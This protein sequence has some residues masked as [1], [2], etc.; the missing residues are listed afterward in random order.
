MSILK[1]SLILIPVFMLLSACGGGDGCAPSDGRPLD[2]TTD[3]S[4]NCANTRAAHALSI[5]Y[6]NIDAINQLDGGGAGIYSYKGSILV[7]DQNGNAVADD[8]IVQL[9]VFDTLIVRGTIAAGDTISGSIITDNAGIVQGDDTTATTINTAV[10]TRNLDISRGVQVGDLV[11]LINA[12]TSDR[13][14]YVA[15]TTANSITVNTPY[16]N[17]YPSALYPA[18]QYLVGQALIPA[19]VLGTDPDDETLKTRGVSKTR[20]GVAAFRLEYPNNRLGYGNTFS[21]TGD[22]RE[23]PFGS[24]SVW[25]VANVGGS[26]ATASP[27]SFPG[28]APGQILISPGVIPGSQ[29]VTITVLDANNGIMAFT[30]VG[31]GSGPGGSGPGC[32]TDEDGQCDSFVTVSGTAG[33]I[34][35]SIGTATGD[36]TY[37][38]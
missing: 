33:T 25:V 2:T 32:V 18:A 24:A 15:S 31:A 14:R 19:S 21:Y 17:T 5:S 4:A 9:D 35:Y 28:I 38:P 29:N 3:T 36:V 7:T 22:T 23:L 26:V 16:N 11:L 37:T 1:Q 8:T 10:V 20:N 13:I 30:A 12:A 34:T 6:P 27:I